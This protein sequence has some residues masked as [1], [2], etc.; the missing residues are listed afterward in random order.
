MPLIPMA[1][2]SATVWT[3][4]PVLPTLTRQMQTMTEGVMAAM[5]ARRTLKTMQTEMGS[6]PALTTALVFPMLIRQM[7]MGTVSV[8]PA[9]TVSTIPTPARKTGMVTESVMLSSAMR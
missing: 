7:E 2:T 9:I 8:M 1:M 3:T 4:A 6:V 5:H